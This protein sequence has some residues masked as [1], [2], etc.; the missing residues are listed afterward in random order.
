MAR[1]TDGARIDE[2]YTDGN[3][4]TAKIADGVICCVDNEVA[5]LP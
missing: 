3:A 2:E 1:D 5:G 4:I